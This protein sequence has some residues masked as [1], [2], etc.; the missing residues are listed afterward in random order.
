MRAELPLILLL[1][2]GCLAAQEPPPKPHVLPG[3]EADEAD[4]NQRVTPVVKAVRRAADSVVSVYIGNQVRN[5]LTNA[6]GFSAQGQGSGVV[7]DE[8]GLVITN[9]HVVALAQM[10]QDLELHV[11]LKDGRHFPAELLS[12]SAED[13]LALLQMQLPAGQTVK[14][15]TTGQ[16]STLEVGETVIAI[17][18][19]QGHANTVT[20]GVLSATDRE[21]T[22]RAPDGA[23]R[24]FTGLLQTDAA[25]NQGNSGGALLDLTGRLVGINSAMAVGVENIG[26]AIPV[27]TMLRVFRDKLLATETLAHIWLGMQIAERDGT[28][29]VTDVDPFGPA[30]EAG[31]RTGDRIV[32]IG[33][34][35]VHRTVD[36]ARRI[37]NAEPGRALPLAVQRNQ[38]Q[39][40]LAPVPVAA[41]NM[42]LLRRLGLLVDLVS[43]E[44]DRA[45]VVKATQEFYAGSGY[46]QVPMLRLVLRI[47]RVQPE[48]PAAE[49]GLRPGDVMYG[50]RVPQRYGP[51]RNLAIPSLEDFNDLLRDLRGNWITLLLMRGDELQEGEIYPR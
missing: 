22:V 5:R 8:Q 41:A 27:D 50:V 29:L 38:S 4:L 39:L 20:V 46:R 10:R 36:Y 40:R 16:S 6:A 15:V 23:M 43:P 47:R 13:D 33:D 51:S 45:L 3:L 14:P 19:P 11:R 42:E 18:N 31:L 9:W 37:L 32:S 12:T 49:L 44:Q 26:F 1:L 21:I 48:S 7:L 35:E 30:Q 24:R 28:L 25:I 17:G 34:Q 2:G